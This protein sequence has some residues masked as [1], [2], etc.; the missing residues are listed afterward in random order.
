MKIIIAGAGRI[1]Y[2]IAAELSKEKN[3]ISVIECN[4][5]RV[6]EIYNSLDIQVYKG[7]GANYDVLAQAG[8]ANADLVIAVTHADETNLLC[9][10]TAKKLGTK[11][12]IARV[13]DR[14][15]RKQ[16][17]LLK[18]ELG[19]TMI[20]NPE[21]A[22]A[23]EI[24][25]ILRYPAASKVEP[26]ANSRAESVEIRVG[27]DSPLNG[28]Q[29]SNFHS[30]IA[31]KVL[32]SAVSRGKE[33][34]IPRGDFT[35]QTGD[36]LNLIGSYKEM[37][38]FLRKN[39][40][41]RHGIKTVLIL[42]AGR[43]TSYLIQRIINSGMKVKIIEKNERMCEELKLA[44][45]KAELVLADGT[46]SEVLLEEG[47]ADADAFLAATGDDEDNVITSMYALSLGTRKVI[48][49]INES[50]IIKMLAGSNLDSIVQPSS[51][52]TQRVV[53]YVRSV[54]N[55]Y[56]T[57]SVDRMYYMFEGRV[58]A[59]EFIINENT[60]FIGSPIKDLSLASDVLIA[61]IIRKGVCII[62]SGDDVISP[63][64]SVIITTT[65]SAISRFE[66]IVEDYIR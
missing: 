20:I 62:P 14:E 54:Q 61:A 52:A 60:P 33:A 22:T 34:I 28:L 44:F 30:K 3:D 19:I 4:E 58:E 51:I 29:I 56:D 59:L 23:N 6:E 57:N 17:A 18:D 31:D 64:D 16:I 41:F 53:Q 66:D 49:K 21:E 12:T 15:Y 2:S 32:I 1:G 40:S 63:G 11:R 45:P 8:A 38:N 46:K 36:R 5:T 7:N 48:T 27:E 13:R 55:A 24:S 37:N 9:C 47:L 65:R 10:L 39:N 50:H 43:T 25:R 35:L 26:F 42:G